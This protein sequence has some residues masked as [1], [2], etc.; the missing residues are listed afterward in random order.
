[1]NPLA[2]NGVCA[3]ALAATTRTAAAQIATLDDT[4]TFL[5]PSSPSDNR[6]FGAPDDTVRIS[7]HPS[8]SRGTMPTRHLIRLGPSACNYRKNRVLERR[9]PLRFYRSGQ[10][11]VTIEYWLLAV[12]IPDISVFNCFQFAPGFPDASPRQTGKRFY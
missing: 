6:L 7:E 11:L 10:E 3:E 4:C 2:A 1:L 9:A 5:I 12:A 8:C